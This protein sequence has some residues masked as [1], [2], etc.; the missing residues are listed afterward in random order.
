MYCMACSSTATRVLDSRSAPRGA[1]RRR[2]ECAGCGER[3]TTFERADL[4]A[5]E[6]ERA[7]VDYVRALTATEEMTTHGRPCRRVA[8]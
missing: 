4:V 2:R 5:D 6:V 1:V 3:F 7:V 8:R